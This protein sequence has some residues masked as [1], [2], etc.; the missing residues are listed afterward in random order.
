[1]YDV[2]VANGRFLAGG[3]KITPDAEPDDGLFDVS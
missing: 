2:I 3:M 1:M